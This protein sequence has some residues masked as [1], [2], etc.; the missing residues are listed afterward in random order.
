MWVTIGAS[1]VNSLSLSKLK[2]ESCN[3]ALTSESAV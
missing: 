1:R 3:V 2:S